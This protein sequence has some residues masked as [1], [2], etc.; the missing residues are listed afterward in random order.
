MEFTADHDRRQQNPPPLGAQDQFITITIR[1]S[2]VVKIL[3]QFERR[4]RSQFTAYGSASRCLPLVAKKNHHY[5]V[6]SGVYCR[7]QTM[8]AKTVHSS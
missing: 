8:L 1:D 4:S 7:L 2:L 5:S 6:Q 3:M